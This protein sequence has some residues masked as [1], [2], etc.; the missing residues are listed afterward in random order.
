MSLH[1][2][3]EDEENDD[4]TFLSVCDDCYKDNEYYMEDGKKINFA[5]KG[6]FVID[7][8]VREND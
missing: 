8:S 5:D 4:D 7:Y 2:N 6:S 1:G 3:F